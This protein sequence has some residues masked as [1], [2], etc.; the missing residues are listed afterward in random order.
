VT[1]EETETLIAKTIED[2]EFAARLV[3]DPAA[4]AKELGLD[5]D[6]ETV[7][8]LSGMSVDDVRAFAEEYRSAT[9]PEHRRA[10]C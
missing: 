9:D 6:A 3:A 10:A 7:E 8:T 5:L 4:A 2:D 1:G